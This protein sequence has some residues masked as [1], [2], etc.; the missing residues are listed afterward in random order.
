MNK[1]NTTSAVDVELLI[2]DLDGTISSTT[3][4]I[5][6]AV[7]RAFNRL[8]L[9]LQM[10]PIEM[11]KYFG[12]P[13]PEFY[14]ALTPPGSHV[15]WQE[16]KE[17]IHEEQAETYRLFGE[18]YPGVKE[19]LEILRKR[20]YKL[21]LFSNSTPGYFDT[22]ID[23]LEI[24]GYFDY[25]ECIGENNLTKS[26]LAGKI[27]TEFGN[28]GTAVVGDR[29]H[30][31]E[32][33][34]DN[35]SLSVGSLYGYGGSEPE[36]ADF[37]IDKFT[38]LL[39]IFDRRIPVFEKVLKVIISRKQPDHPFIIGITGIDASGKSLFTEAL[40]HFLIRNNYPVQIIHM[41]DFHNPQKIRYAGE[42]AANNYF[43]LSFNIDKVIDELLI[44]IHK[45]GSLSTELT[46]L[47]LDTDSFRNK[48]SYSVS[49]DTIVLLEG[50]FLFRKEFSP[51][52][53]YYV[54]LDI[55]FEECLK[56]GLERGGE[57]ERYQI[58][59][60]PAQKKYL[61]AYPPSEH[62]DII[63]DNSNW[64]YPVITSN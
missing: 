24:R 27:R 20:G 57:E 38:E 33:A 35:N 61:V 23:A 9:T 3:R 39:D 60:I 58:K 5:Y 64:E 12:A 46:V 6:E 10:T 59:Y 11:E 28:P 7:K 22:V 50:V 8:D 51:Y 56:R 15:T 31:L 14:I 26:K 29:I 63:I 2:F 17:K 18:T 43:N 32:A 47:D 41:D 62:A 45:K 21:A 44:P 19:T 13:S 37:T 40:N 55:S 52:V 30:D 16:I 1:R 4:P 42:N 53:N 49:T 34:R 36:E 48:H 54:Y 25:T